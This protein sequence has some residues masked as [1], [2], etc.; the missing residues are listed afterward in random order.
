MC[1]FGGVQQKPQNDKRARRCY[2]CAPLG[3]VLWCRVSKTPLHRQERFCVLSKAAPRGLCLPAPPLGCERRSDT[4]APCSLANEAALRGT[5]RW[6]AGPSP[7]GIDSGCPPCAAPQW[8]SH[9]CC[10]VY[11]TRHLPRSRRGSRSA[12][13]RFSNLSDIRANGGKQENR[14]N[15]RKRDQFG[16]VA[17]KRG[18]DAGREHH[19]AGEDRH[20]EQ[21]DAHRAQGECSTPCTRGIPPG[22][23]HQSFPVDSPQ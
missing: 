8:R 1:F 2:R 14:P 9:L 12:S 23:H 20:D 3:H 15:R 18:G 17:R 6:S 10:A 11:D 19:A 7:W 4:K 21:A 5:Q 22:P 16:A 13:H